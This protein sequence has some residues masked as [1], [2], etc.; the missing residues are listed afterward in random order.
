MLRVLL[1]LVFLVLLLMLPALRMKTL[2]T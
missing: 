1:L 2:L